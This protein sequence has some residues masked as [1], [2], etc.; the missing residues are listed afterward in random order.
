MEVSTSKGNVSKDVNTVYNT[1]KRKYEHLFNVS[2]CEY[3]EDFLCIVQQQLEN[4]ITDHSGKEAEILNN[5]ISNDDVKK[6]VYRAKLNKAGAFKNSSNLAIRG[7]MGWSTVKTKQNIEVLR[8]DFKITCLDENRL[9]K[10][11]HESSKSKQRSW[12][13]GVLEFIQKCDLSCLINAQNMTTRQKISIVKDKLNTMD[14]ENWLSDL[15]N[16]RNC[17]NGN[18]LRTFRQYKSYL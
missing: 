5:N 8:L 1:W 2:D 3:N 14:A 18:K 11:I 15:Y 7:D 12:H 10:E 4:G 16:D 13:S 9:V 17:E 6:A